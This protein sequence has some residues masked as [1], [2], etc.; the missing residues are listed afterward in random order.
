MTRLIICWVLLQPIPLEKFLMLL[1]THGNTF[2]SGEETLHY[3]VRA[4][5]VSFGILFVSCL[6]IASNPKIGKI[7]L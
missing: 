3:C 7:Y 4:D 6:L 5:R 1:S 2:K